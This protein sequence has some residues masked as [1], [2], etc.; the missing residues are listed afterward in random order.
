MYSSVI[1]RLHAMLWSTASTSSS[2]R[3][4]STAARL[5]STASSSH[6]ANPV[7]TRASPVSPD[8][9][10]SPRAPGAVER[11][12]GLGNIENRQINPRGWC[13][14]R[15]PMWIVPCRLFRCFCLEVA[16]RSAADSCQGGSIYA[17]RSRGSRII[18]D[19]RVERHHTLA[20]HQQQHHRKRMAL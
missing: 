4:A 8:I 16:N 11:V 17:L 6:S 18:W 13:H 2:S 9:P 12:S 3:R 15:Q 5:S 20:A 1:P 7:G 14:W 19:L 10:T